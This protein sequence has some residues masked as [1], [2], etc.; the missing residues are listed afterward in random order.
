MFPQLAYFLSNSLSLISLSSPFSSGVIGSY[1]HNTVRPSLGRVAS[2][3]SL[4]FPAAVST[5]TEQLTVLQL[6][7]D[8]LAMHTAGL[9]PAHL[10][11]ASVPADAVQR[12]ES[13]FAVCCC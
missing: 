5:N 9:K 3:V 12:E 8:R 11:R 6:L 4:K 10:N 13:A 1:V 7:A 2:L